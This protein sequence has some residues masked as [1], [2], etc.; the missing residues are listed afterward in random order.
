MNQNS[1]YEK[2]FIAWI[3]QQAQLLKNHNFEQ[4]DLENLVEELL[5]LIHQ[6]QHFI[7]HHSYRLWYYLLTEK[8]EGFPS[9]AIQD[10]HRS[11][12]S[13]HYFMLKS[14]LESSSLLDYFEEEYE[15]IYQR[16]A[17]N[18]CCDRG[19]WDKIKLPPQPPISRVDFLE[20][21]YLYWLL[22]ERQSEER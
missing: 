15:E 3:K 19:D 14:L 7:D 1:L 2:D 8:Y 20:D 11:K 21:G 9:E 5:C 22:Q 13:Y 6:E 18:W 10:W 17:F 12:A 4:L 16:V